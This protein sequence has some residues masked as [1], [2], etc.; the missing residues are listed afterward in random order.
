MSWRIEAQIKKERRA[1][2]GH[3]DTSDPQVKE[4]MELW[5]A[6]VEKQFDAEVDNVFKR[7]IDL[8][9][10]LANV[11]QSRGMTKIK[12]HFMIHIRPADDWGKTVSDFIDMIH[13]IAK[14]KSIVTAVYSF[15]QKGTTP[16]TLGSGYHAHMVVEHTRCTKGQVADAINQLIKTLFVT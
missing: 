6:A 14:S 4:C 13:D 8:E 12:N 1:L 15:K 2:F 7:A 3:L 10:K 9:L 5:K 16:E 11:R